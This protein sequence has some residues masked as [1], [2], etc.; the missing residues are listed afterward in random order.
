MADR[1]TTS[2]TRAGRPRTR[3][4][5]VHLPSCISV[6]PKAVKPR[7]KSVQRTLT[8]GKGKGTD[9]GQKTTKKTNKAV[10][11]MSL[12]SEDLEVYFPHYPQNQPYEVPTDLPQEPNPP[13]DI[14]VE[15]PEEAGEQKEPQHPMHIPVEDIEQP[16]DPGNPNLIPVQPPIPMANNQLKWSHFRPEFSGTPYEDVEAHLLRTEDW[17]TIHNVPEDQ[18]VG[19][20]CLTL[21]GEARLWYA[22]LNIQ[23]QQLNWEGLQDRFR[24]QYYQ[25]CNTREQYFHV[26]RSFQF[27]EATDTIDGYIQKVKQVAALLDYGDPQ[28]LELFKNTLPSRLYYKLY[29][30]DNLREAV[31]MAKRILTKEQMDEKA[32]L[33]STSPF[34]QVNQNNSKSNDKMKKKVSFSAVEAMERTRDSIEILASLMDRMDRKL[35]RRADQYR[36]RFYQGRNRGCGYRQNSYGSRNRSYS[37]DQY[38][39][40]YRGRRNYSNRGGNRNYRSNY[41]DNSR[42]RDRNS[43]R[44]DNMYNHRSNDRREDRNQR[45][46]DRSQDHSRPRDGDRRNQSSSRESSQSRSRSQNR[47]KSRRQSRD[48]TRNRDRSE[49]R[50]RSSSHVSTNGDRSRCY[51]CNEYDH[52]ARECPN[53][54]PGRNTNNAEN[55]LLGMTDAG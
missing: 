42:S 44:D 15:G 28:I 47:Y 2:M 18:K 6:A 39:N 22:T 37:W 32:G 25:F 51:R 16:W 31:E 9:K 12:D 3:S 45:Y 20:F 26:W 40:N 23:Q 54:A 35:D 29:H 30:I 8:I 46:G 4:R 36:P 5:S 55:S 14:P 43:Y 1:P 49:S 52:F 10:A 27:D 41:R 33:S 24:Q 34:M 11:V 53:N 7:T 21:M 17:M 13:A 19:R 50:S 48:D 38:Q